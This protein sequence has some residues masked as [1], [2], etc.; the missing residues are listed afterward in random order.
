M[1]HQATIN[2]NKWDIRLILHADLTPMTVANFVTLA[3][4]GFYDGL[5]FHRVISD[6]MIQTG[7]PQGTGTWW[8]WYAFGDEF[9]KDLKHDA[10]GI[11]S[12][13]NSW[14]ASNGSQF[15]I[16]HT[17][18]TRLDG[19]HTVFGKVVDADD[20]KIVNIISQWDIINTITIHDEFLKLD[21]ETADFVIQINNFIDKTI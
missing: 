3:K 15:F 16:T 9:T 17:P 7:C 6:F 12:M 2:T 21:P 20:Q 18:T 14:P 4:G 5:K 13:A 11:L 19:K 1:T 10:P 8:P